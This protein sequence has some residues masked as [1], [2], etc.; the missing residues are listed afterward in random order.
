MRIINKEALSFDDVILIPQYSDLKTRRNINT[1]VD[2]K[3]NNKTLSFK[4]IWKVRMT[5]FQKTE[6][7]M[8]IF[9]L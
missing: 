8:Y 2:I 7:H 5:N 3:F 4:L 1:N 9:F 6:I